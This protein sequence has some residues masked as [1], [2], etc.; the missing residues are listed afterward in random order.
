MSSRCSRR[1][2]CTPS[3]Q[4][5]RSDS[6]LPGRWPP[7]TP[8]GW[9][10]TLT[11]THPTPRITR[12][13]SRDIA[14]HWEEAVNFA[15]MARE[16]PD[17]SILHQDLYGSGASFL[18]QITEEL[19]DDLPSSMTSDDGLEGWVTD[20]D[21]RSEQYSSDE[22][23]TGDIFFDATLKVTSATLSLIDCPSSSYDLT[24]A[25]YAQSLVD[26]ISAL[27]STGALAW[28]F[29][30]KAIELNQFDTSV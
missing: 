17:L 12:A 15:N 5:E 10:S 30:D 26:G 1:G 3:V 8:Q 23:D 29:Q 4:S 14:Q 13:R 18:P 22:S 6:D 9:P 28:L 19:S 7:S 2:S 24:L 11:S 27:A 20:S 16:E 25:E 21:S